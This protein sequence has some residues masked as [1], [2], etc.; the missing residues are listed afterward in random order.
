MAELAVEIYGTL[1]GFGRNFDLQGSAASMKPVFTTRGWK[2]HAY[3]R[4][5][6]RAAP[7]RINSLLDTP[8]DRT[9]GIGK[10]VPL[11]YPISG[12]WSRWITQ[13]HRLAFQVLEADLVVDR[14]CDDRGAG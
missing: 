9:W 11:R 4:Q 3:W 8:R 10:P 1:I 13:D 5:I 6:D 7:M 14:S 2:H 12:T